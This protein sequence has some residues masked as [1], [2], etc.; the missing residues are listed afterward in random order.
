MS[1]PERRSD[2]R[3]LLN[4]PVTFRCFDTTRTEEVTTEATNISRSGM[5][6]TSPRPLAVGSSLRM[7]LRVPIEISGSVFSQLQCIGRVVHERSAVGGAMGYGIAIEKMT[8]D[9]RAHVESARPLLT[10]P[11]A[12]A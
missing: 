7:S 2:P 11:S 6:I 10:R 9:L 12:A 1:S 4:I 3:Y 5:F 8:R